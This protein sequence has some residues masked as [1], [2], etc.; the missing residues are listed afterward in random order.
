MPEGNTKRQDELSE[1]C[2]IALR[3]MFNFDCLFLRM[4]L[5][6]SSISL[7]LMTIELN[8]LQ[9]MAGLH[10]KISKEFIFIGVETICDLM[11]ESVKN[12]IPFLG[13]ARWLQLQ[14]PPV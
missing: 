13:V 6:L 3:N 11:D 9:A 4:T 5:N 8:R 14:V 7:C 1:Y 2:F 10:G 12:P